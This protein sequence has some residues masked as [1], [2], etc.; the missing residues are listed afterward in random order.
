MYITKDFKGK[1][2]LGDFDETFQRLYG[3]RAV[4]QARQRYVDAVNE[5][6]RVFDQHR[7]VRVFSAPGRSELGG[8]H[9]DH[10]QGH[11]L[12]AAVELDILAM[13]SNWP[14]ARSL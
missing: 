10:Q 7:T 14:V 4:L 8:N 3:R 2:L 13:A 11:V 5:F 12:A 1:I 9:T 6:E